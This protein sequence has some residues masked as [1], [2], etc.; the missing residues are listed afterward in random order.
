MIMTPLMTIYIIFG[1]I[2]FVG[3]IFLLIYDN[4]IKP[5]I[6]KED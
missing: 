5:R 1:S 3:I 6:N 2:A 4:V